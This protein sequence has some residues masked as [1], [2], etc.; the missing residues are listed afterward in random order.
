MRTVYVVMHSVLLV[1]EI[2]VNGY[3]TFSYDISPRGLRQLRWLVSY[4]PWLTF[5]GCLAF[6][7]GILRRGLLAMSRREVIRLTSAYMPTMWY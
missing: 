3:E 4:Y 5:R 1:I 6:L 7:C 2:F